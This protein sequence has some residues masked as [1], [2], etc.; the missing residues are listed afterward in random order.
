L[1]KTKG[2]NISASPTPSNK[3]RDTSTGIRH[4]QRNSMMNN[5]KQDRKASCL[6]FNHRKLSEVNS[7]VNSPYSPIKL[8]LDAFKKYEEDIVNNEVEDI[9]GAGRG[10]FGVGAGYSSFNLGQLNLEDNRLSNNIRNYRV[11]KI[12]IIIYFFCDF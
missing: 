2:I 10:S 9:I 5:I 12:N 1:I 4:H 11:S 7:N 8:N 6:N 3:K